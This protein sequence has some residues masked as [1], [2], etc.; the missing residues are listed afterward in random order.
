MWPKLVFLLFALSILAGCIDA[1]D[2]WDGDGASGGNEASVNETASQPIDPGWPELADA[3]I[4][5]GV[6]VTSSAGQCTSNFVFQSPDNHTL[7]LGLAAHCLVGDEPEENVT[8]AG[9]FDAR[10]V[11]NAFYVMNNMN[12]T[13]ISSGD[14]D[15][16]LIEIPDEHRDQVHPAMHH[17]GGPVALAEGASQGERIITYG[18][19]G[20]RQGVEPSNPREGYVFESS[21][22]YTSMWI[23]TPG[24]WGD[25]GSAVLN[26]H[27]E[28]LGVLVHLGPAPASNGA[29]NL[30]PAM[31]WAKEQTG[32]EVELSTWEL[33][34]PGLLP[35]LP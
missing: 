35:N 25:S 34:D 12:D 31:E 24:V 29:T 3:G 6:Q 11:Y 20:M 16:A 14:N 28:A 33:I 5:P 15:F 23:V 13:G 17:F 30:A 2:P 26:G 22:R 8:I 21:E 9:Q 7:Y 32:I 18:H 4:R 10:A 27:G 19:S 1:G